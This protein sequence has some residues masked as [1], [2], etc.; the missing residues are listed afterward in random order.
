ML[1]RNQLEWITN[2]KAFIFKS[3][4]GGLRVVKGLFHSQIAMAGYKTR[5]LGLVGQH[6]LF[7]WNL[8]CL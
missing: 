4:Q 3:R 1:H 2:L 7:P 5:K 6:R 8:T